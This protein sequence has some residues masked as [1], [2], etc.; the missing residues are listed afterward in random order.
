M[1]QAIVEGSSTR[2]FFGRNSL[3]FWT[4]SKRTLVKKGGQS[5]LVQAPIYLGQRFRWLE[6][7]DVDDSN[8]TGSPHSGFLPFIFPL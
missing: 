5:S 7:I 8:N 1:V 2:N 6:L 4:C 3:P